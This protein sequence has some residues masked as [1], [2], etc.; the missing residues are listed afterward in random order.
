M[1]IHFDYTNEQ[2][3]AMLQVASERGFRRAARAASVLRGGEPLVSPSGDPE[4][5]AVV[6]ADTSPVPAPTNR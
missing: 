4:D 1:T 3:G 5:P 2:L 6:P